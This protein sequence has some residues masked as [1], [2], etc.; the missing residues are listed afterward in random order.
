MATHMDLD[1][2]PWDGT[3][4]RPMGDVWAA[5]RITTRPPMGQVQENL[6]HTVRIPTVADLKRSCRKG[7]ISPRFVELDDLRT[8]AICAGLLDDEPMIGKAV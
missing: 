6:R 4:V 5:C 3:Y 1:H 7:R 2:R 8:R